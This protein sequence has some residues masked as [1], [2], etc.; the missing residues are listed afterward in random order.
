M[1]LDV[2]SAKEVIFS[3]LSVGLLFFLFVC[4][5][6]GLLNGFL[7]NLVDV[8]QERTYQMLTLLLKLREVFFFCDIFTDFTGKFRHI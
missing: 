8:G 6:A 1:L 7:R 4:L 2:A 5:S 3:P